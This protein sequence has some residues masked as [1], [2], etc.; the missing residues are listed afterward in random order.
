MVNKVYL[1]MN[2]CSHSWI[3]PFL[4]LVLIQKAPKNTQLTSINTISLVT[5]TPDFCI[6]Q[7]NFLGTPSTLLWGLAEV[8]AFYIIVIF[9]CFDLYVIVLLG[10]IG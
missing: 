3:K 4:I 8:L 6:E 1:D 2:I 5:V 7:S 9:L 10:M